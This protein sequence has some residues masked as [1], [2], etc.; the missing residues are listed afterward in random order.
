MAPS[1]TTWG[2]QTRRLRAPRRFVAS[3]LLEQ[4][5]SAR[6]VQVE[7]NHLAKRCAG[8]VSA[9]PAA[10]DPAGAAS[11]G[12]LDICAAAGP[13]RARVIRCIAAGCDHNFRELD[14]AVEIAACSQIGAIFLVVSTRAATGK[15]RDRNPAARTDGRPLTSIGIA[16]RHARLGWAVFA[17]NRP[18]WVP[19]RIERQSPMRRIRRRKAMRIG[20]HV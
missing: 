4:V 14:D 7:P 18:E 16:A 12:K 8:E 15:N 3:N 11:A 20:A 17:L 10:A 9:V 5:F 19:S 1:S 2:N 13:V 6:D